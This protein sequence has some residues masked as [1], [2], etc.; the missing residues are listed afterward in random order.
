M[1]AVKPVRV[2]CVEDSPFFRKILNDILGHRDEIEL[3]G[4]PGDPYEARDRLAATPVDVMTLDLELPRMAG[5]TFLKLVMERKPMPVIILSS[6]TPVGSQ[7]AVEALILGAFAVI[8]KPAN[9]S[10]RQNFDDRL[11]REIKNAASAP[12][13]RSRPLLL[14]RCLEIQQ[15]AFPMYDSRQIIALGASTGGTQALEEVLTKLPANLPG[16]LIVQHIPAGF[17]ASF[18]ERLNRACAMEVREA[19]NGDI[20]SPGLALIAP[21]D[22][23][24]VIQWICGH[25]RVLLNDEPAVEHQRPS[26]DVLFKSLARCAGHQTVAV[27]LT[28]MGRD[29]AA[30]M[31]RLHDLN[32]LTI[33]QD[34]AS[35]VVYGMARQAVE[36]EAVDTVV[37]L[38]NIASEIMK[39][40]EKRHLPSTPTTYAQR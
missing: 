39:A 22:K 38:E 16:I 25:Y 34:A 32:A 37:P 26:V 35:S 7:K 10:E 8:E 6:L 1:S 23:H 19:K 2:L 30:G 3:V 27:L 20:I 12:L 13:R 15:P 28:G 18:A 24:M 11:I 9:L 17:S 36:L 4:C 31:K 40:L 5:L 33:A 21:G 29:G 14:N